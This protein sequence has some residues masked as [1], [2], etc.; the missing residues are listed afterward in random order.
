MKSADCTIMKTIIAMFYKGEK[1]TE[2][3]AEEAG[4]SQKAATKHVEW[5]VKGF[6]WKS[7]RILKQN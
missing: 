4:C 7:W 3:S 6:F 5:K 1:A 2:K